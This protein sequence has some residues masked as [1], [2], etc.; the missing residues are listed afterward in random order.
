M[1]GELRKTA[2]VPKT[3]ASELE[4]MYNGLYKNLLLWTGVQLSLVV[5]ERWSLV[6][7]RLYCIPLAG[8]QEISN[9]RTPS[10]HCF[11]YSFFSSFDNRKLTTVNNSC[12]YSKTYHQFV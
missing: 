10:I 12:N 11:N 6:E 7:V 4:T 3:D 2:H 1:Y 8:K 5:T 9:T